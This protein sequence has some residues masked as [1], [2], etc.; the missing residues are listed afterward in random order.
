[1]L[2]LLTL[3]DAAASSARAGSDVAPS[4]FVTGALCKLSV[5]LVK[6]NEV[7][8]RKA[9][10]VYATASGTRRCHRYLHSAHSGP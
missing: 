8:N 6:G 4:S 2:F 10:H 3:A 1:M 9:M 5:A 7:V